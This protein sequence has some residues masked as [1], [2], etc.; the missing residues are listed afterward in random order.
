MK[1]PGH[2]A[3]YSAHEE[4]GTGSAVLDPYVLQPEVVFSLTLKGQ[5]ETAAEID[6]LASS[7]RMSFP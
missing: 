5:L 3:A 2:S 1:S 4:D 6:R 7:D